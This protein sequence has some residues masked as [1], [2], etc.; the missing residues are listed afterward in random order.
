MYTID[1]VKKKIDQ[2]ALSAIEQMLHPRHFALFLEGIRRERI[3]SFR[4]NPLKGTRLEV[5]EDLRRSGVQF[6]EFQEIPLS[7]QLKSSSKDLM[8]CQSYKSGAIYLQG[9]SGMM[10]P[11]LL[12]PQKGEKILDLA[13]SPGSKVTMVSAL[14]ENSGHIDALEPDFIRM[15]RLKHNCQLLGVENIDFH[16]IKAQSFDAQEGSYDGILADV[17]CSGEGRFNLFDTAS[18]RFWKKADPQKFSNLQIKILKKAVTLLRPGGRLVYSTCTLNSF[19][20]ETVMETLLSENSDLSSVPIER[21]K[22][23]VDE[24]VY[25]QKGKLH[26]LRI[27]PSPRF[28][29][30]FY[31]VLRKKI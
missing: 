27:I 19:E 1:E 12:S 21:C 22:S 14:M 4:I 11:F 15:E 9:L 5:I 18:Y 31:C 13:A 10:A 25:S 2:N 6:H 7:F 8:K 3:E 30:F 28:E 29:G 24:F 26:G 16:Q 20:N 17:P 23:P